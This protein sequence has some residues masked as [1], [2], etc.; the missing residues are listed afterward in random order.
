MVSPN[1]T[2]VTSAIA[3]ALAA[4][5]TVGA[6]AV[7]CIALMYARRAAREAG[8]QVDASLDSAK[9]AQDAARSAQDQVRLLEEQLRVSEP[10]P[11]LLL[12]IAW[13]VGTLTSPMSQIENVGEELAFHVEV[14]DVA[15]VRQNPYEVLSSLRIA[16]EPLIR[17]GEHTQLKYELDPPLRIS[18]RQ[19]QRADEALRHF[20]SRSV[21]E[22]LGYSATLGHD[23]DQRHELATIQLTYKNVRGRS[24]TSDFILSVINQRI[25]ECYLRTI[26]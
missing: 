18:D 17:V 7:A 9:A 10:R 26:G 2:E 15:I 25:V 8:R 21:S 6:A 11:V 19:N 14:S 20:L 22:A 23:T 16:E 4:I 3:S 13:T 24:F 12:R 1:W 5:A